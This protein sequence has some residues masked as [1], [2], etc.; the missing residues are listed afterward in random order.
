MGKNVQTKNAGTQLFASSQLRVCNVC[1]LFCVFGFILYFWLCFFF[2]GCCMLQTW[3]A[4]QRQD[5]KQQTK[6]KHALSGVP[7]LFCRPHVMFF[8]VICML[9]VHAKTKPGSWQMTTLLVKLRNAHPHPKLLSFVRW[10]FLGPI[11]VFNQLLYAGAF[12]SVLLLD[13]V[14]FSP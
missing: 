7:L 12:R 14:F 5:C 2:L 8:C 13:F 11:C 1:N 3:K 4:M 10:P 6:N 9:T